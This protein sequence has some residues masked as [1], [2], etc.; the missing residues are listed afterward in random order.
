MTRSADC[1][2][3]PRHPAAADRGAATSDLG[4][5]REHLEEV[6][7]GH[8]RSRWCCAAPAPSA[9]SRRSSSSRSPAASPSASCSSGRSAAGRCTASSTSTTTRTSPSPT[10]CRRGRAG[11]RLRGARRLRVH[12]RGAG[13]PP[14]RA[15]R[16]PGM[17]R[18]C[19]PSPSTLGRLRPGVPMSTSTTA[20][21]ARP[22]AGHPRRGGP[23]SATATRRGNV[24]AGG[25]SYFAFFS[26]F[27][28]VA[29][30]FTVFGFVL[31]G[32][33]DLLQA[34]ADALS[35]PARASSRTPST[36][37]GSSRSRRRGT[38]ALTIA[39]WSAS[40]P[41]CWPAWAG[42]ARCAT[43]SAAVFGVEGSPGNMVT[44]KLR[45]L[46]VLVDHRPGDRRLGHPHQHHRRRR[47][48]G[49]RPR[50]AGRQ[51]LGGHDG[52]RAG[53]RRGRHRP[54]GLLLRL[55]SG[56]PLPGHDLAQGALLGGVG[57]TVLKLLG[58]RLS[59]AR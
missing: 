18:R 30:A 49:G 23:G 2:P 27:P 48:L 24:L 36:R 4:R 15:R 38:G 41:W 53:R 50:R 44:T 34:V 7:A 25:V 22:P 14:L 40:S 12:L 59:A 58:A 28:A 47:G 10:T 8:A 54:D 11:P 45:D 21:A 19:T 9:R 16:R 1:D 39:G 55:L 3:H 5:G 6:A 43:A 20:V 26:I 37:T 56:V 42:S 17:A 29:L 33:P 57:F 51:R 46:G 31:Q 32:R 52:R 35:R 13:V